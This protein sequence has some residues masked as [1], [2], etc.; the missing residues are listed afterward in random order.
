MKDEPCRSAMPLSL[1]TT[2]PSMAARGRSLGGS[3][4]ALVGLVG[5]ERRVAGTMG[6]AFWRTVGANGVS[7]GMG[8]KRG[9]LGTEEE[10]RIRP[11]WTAARGWGRHAPHACVRVAKC[12]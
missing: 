3:L 2:V 1:D 4:G 5:T 7:G 8:G 10:D 9:K 11:G 12:R 6:M